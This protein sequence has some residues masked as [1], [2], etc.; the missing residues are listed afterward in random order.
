MQGSGHET[1][2]SEAQVVHP[3]LHRRHSVVHVGSELMAVH[4]RVAPK[5]WG[6]GP[7]LEVM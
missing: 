4:V 6:P 7:G 2:L 5:P 1:D 3:D